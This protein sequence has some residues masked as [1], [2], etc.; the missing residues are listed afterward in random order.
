LFLCAGVAQ[1]QVT[2]YELVTVP[3]ASARKGGLKEAGG[4]VFLNTTGGDPFTTTKS[5]MFRFSAPLATDSPT[6]LGFLG[7]GATVTVTEEDT[8]DNDGNGTIEATVLVV[9]QS[10]AT[11]RGLLFDVSE[12][13]AP[14]TVTV[15][16][17][18]KDSTED[19]VF[20]TLYE[21]PTTAN[22]ITDITLGVKAEAKSST[23]RTRGT[24]AAG[25]EATLTI[26]EGFKGAFMHG[27]A[28]ELEIDGLPNEVK[29]GVVSD[30]VSVNED[31]TDAAP[32]EPDATSTA[33][34]TPR[35]GSVT[36]DED[37]D[38]KIIF[39][40]LGDDVGTD[41]DDDGASIELVPAKF[42][43]TLT[44]TAD[45]GVEDSKVSFPLDISN[46]DARVTFSG[47]DF[48]DAYTSAATIF[49]IRHAQCTM[50]FP[51]V[52]VLPDLG[53][54]TAISITNPGYGTPTADGELMLTFYGND[55]DPVEFSPTMGT[56]LPEDGSG[57]LPAGHV[58][59]ELVSNIL[60]ETNWGDSFQGHVHVLADYPGCTGVGWVTDWM[61]VNQ[62]YNAV[63]IDSD[64]GQ[65]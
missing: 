25:V 16:A 47:S 31:A 59:Q 28:L 13:S 42:T 2:R 24:G 44:L 15:T 39:I 61:G 57:I 18:A 33:T 50:V 20:I 60:K 58:Y 23:V 21:G 65:N 38:D 32:E 51:V 1:A 48:E 62:A 54:D 52:T 45:P 11:I 29:V 22:I 4:T 53:W 64:T 36:G 8:A 49:E 37:G 55:Q 12:T 41:T 26:E 10:T 40:D 17:T 14:V 6:Y 56:G 43:L 19:D 35:V 3:E 27:N 7:T 5:I 9:N 46:I 63:V 34:A 30:K